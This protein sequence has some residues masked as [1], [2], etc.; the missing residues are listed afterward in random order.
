MSHS[1]KLDVVAESVETKEQLEYLRANDCD[2]M[3]GFIFSRPVPAES[4]ER[5]IAKKKS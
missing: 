1:L 4:F 3:Q 2:K 5:L